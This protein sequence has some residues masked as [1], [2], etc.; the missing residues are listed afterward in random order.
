MKKWTKIGASLVAILGLL[1]N[2]GGLWAA[3]VLQID[4][5]TGQ[6]SIQGV[7]GDLKSFKLS[8]RTVEGGASDVIINPGATNDLGNVPGS[9]GLGDGES[10]FARR[11]GT[12]AIM[13]RYVGFTPIEDNNVSGAGPADVNLGAAS[14]GLN[15]AVVPGVFDPGGFASGSTEPTFQA[16]LPHI[17]GL[18]FKPM[19]PALTQASATQN[20]RFEYGKP[21]EQSAFSGAISLIN[22]GTP[23]PPPNPPEPAS[24]TLLGVGL[25]GLVAARRRHNG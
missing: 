5:L 14:G 1:G 17:L 2:A 3:P 12:A 10:Y 6:A 4:W 9:D 11:V 20:L 25:L 23:P 13:A 22:G 8:A 18:M 16:D 24:L 7:L 19:N 21:G 15:S